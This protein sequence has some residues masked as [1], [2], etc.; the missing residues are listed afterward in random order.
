MEQITL[1]RSMNLSGTKKLTNVP[2]DRFGRGGGVKSVLNGGLILKI[3][4]CNV[5]PFQGISNRCFGLYVALFV[6]VCVISLTLLA[7]TGILLFS[8]KYN[9]S[10]EK[11]EEDPKDKQTD[12]TKKIKGR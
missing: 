7:F 9:S 3:F 2:F 10:L 11:Q 4:V 5:M 1:I 12:E 6:L 8:K